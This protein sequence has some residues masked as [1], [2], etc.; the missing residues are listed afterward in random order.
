MTMNNFDF[1]KKNVGEFE[2]VQACS[3]EDIKKIEDELTLKLP[4]L[5]REFLMICGRGSGLFLKEDF[6]H[7]EYL[8]DIQKFG[9]ELRNDCGYVPAKKGDL[10]IA[11][12]WDDVIN[13]INVFEGENPPV[14]TFNRV[15]WM[16][17]LRS[18]SFTSYLNEKLHY[19]LE[20]KCK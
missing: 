20:L 16:P 6:S 10:V 3:E 15:E 4:S 14:Y 19:F 11:T 5:Y 18:N 9:S 7:Y 17:Q 2:N 13:Y 1:F 12:N 8:I